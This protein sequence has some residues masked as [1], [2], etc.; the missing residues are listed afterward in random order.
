MNGLVS[1]GPAAADV[2]VFAVAV[3]VAVVVAAASAAARSAA[4]EARKL[5]R[6]VAVD[7]MFRSGKQ[8]QALVGKK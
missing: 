6:C 4:S 8:Q 3:A 2:V 1:A 5:P 7:E